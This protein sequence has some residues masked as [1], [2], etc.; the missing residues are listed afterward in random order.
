MK[1]YTIAQFDQHGIPF[2]YLNLD[3]TKNVW[4]RELTESCLTFNL[5]M[6]EKIAEE[7]GAFV[8][9]YN[10]EREMPKIYRGGQ[11]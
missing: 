6:L 1:I 11:P 4:V 10:L 9:T 2:R 8:V 3:Q 5:A 7:L